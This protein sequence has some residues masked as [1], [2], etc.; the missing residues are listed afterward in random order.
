MQDITEAKTPLVITSTSV[1]T[2]PENEPG[3][4]QVVNASVERVHVQ[5]ED[6]SSSNQDS[7]EKNTFADTAESVPLPDSIIVQDE[8][9]SSTSADANEALNPIDSV[10]GTSP[11]TSIAN[12]VTVD[13][14]NTVP[15]EEVTE[16]DD[17][18]DDARLEFF[19]APQVQIEDIELA[20]LRHIQ[21]AHQIDLNSNVLDC[22]KRVSKNSKFNSNCFTL[23]L[24]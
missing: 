21:E 12:N 11:S 24:I 9:V 19:E 23:L 20:S 14:E 5:C 16:R 8:R 17:E 10:E 18:D 15:N 6:I 1:D 2:T 3:E 22:I 13:I 4:K 7:P